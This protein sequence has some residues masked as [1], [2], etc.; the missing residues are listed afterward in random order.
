MY[1]VCVTQAFEQL[2]D[3]QLV[4]TS[5]SELSS[6]LLTLEPT[7]EGGCI[8]ESMQNLADKYN[9]TKA[10]L[11]SHLSAQVEEKGES[12]SCDVALVSSWAEQALLLLNHHKSK[13]VIRGSQLMNELAVYQEMLVQV[14]QNVAQMSAAVNRANI[15]SRTD[16][17]NQVES[18]DGKLTTISLALSMHETEEVEEEDFCNRPL[19]GLSSIHFGELDDVI[20]QLTQEVQFPPFLPLETVDYVSDTAMSGF[21]IASVP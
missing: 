11:K 6:Q 1:C 4:L 17:C 13:Q 15:S 10:Q 2:E 16:L 9:E 8:R 5:L 3:H 14:K 19:S 7:F 12:F 20:H 21:A 18:V